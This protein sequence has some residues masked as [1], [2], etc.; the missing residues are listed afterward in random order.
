MKRLVVCA[1]LVG[2]GG[3]SGGG[4]IA[5]EDLGMQLGDVSCQKVF[6]CCTDAEI[7]K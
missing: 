4:P 7:M 1:L 5:I 3:D 2:C 6:E